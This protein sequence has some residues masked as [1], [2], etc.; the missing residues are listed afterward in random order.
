MNHRPDELIAIAKEVLGGE[1]LTVITIF[2]LAGVININQF[3]SEFLPGSKTISGSLKDRKAEIFRLA[4]IYWGLKP[5]DWRKMENVWL[6]SARAKSGSQ[7]TKG[8]SRLNDVISAELLIRLVAT[9]AFVDGLDRYRHARTE[10]LRKSAI[11]S[12]N[13]AISEAVLKGQT[14]IERVG[15]KT[16]YAHLS[17]KEE[18]K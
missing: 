2:Y 4:E 5:Q 13:M 16:I 18:T 15:D 11:S 14:R 8:K 17:K 7:E 9:I 6:K 3:K 12:L 1:P 10:L